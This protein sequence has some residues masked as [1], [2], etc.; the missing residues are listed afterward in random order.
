MVQI[1]IH[2]IIQILVFMIVIQG[3]LILNNVAVAAPAEDPLVVD[4][5]LTFMIFLVSA[6][7]WGLPLKE[8]VHMLL[9]IIHLCLQ[10]LN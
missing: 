5:I 6:K 7:S 9:F 10:I 2:Y 3:M 4:R 1:L 8:V